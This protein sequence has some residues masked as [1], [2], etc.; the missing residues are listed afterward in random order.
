V[1]CLA[2]KKT[3]QRTT[4][5]KKSTSSGSVRDVANTLRDLKNWLF[6]FAQEYD[7]PQE[8]VTVLHAKIDEVGQKLGRL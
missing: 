8:A 2:S 5:A 3:K 7:L 1:I 6:V 4:N